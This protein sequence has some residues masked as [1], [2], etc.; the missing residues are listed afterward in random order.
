MITLP[1][2]LCGAILSQLDFNILWRYFSWSNQTLAMVAF[3][4]ATSYLI[5]EGKNKLY[6]L[7]T[8][9]PGTFMSAVSMTY[10]LSAPEGFAIKTTITY[11]I[12][13]IF[14]IGCFAVYLTALLKKKK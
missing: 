11:P 14:A 13:A 8:A 10:I 2:F 12:G 9:I 5:K 4:V 1:L 7:L 3:W 6:S